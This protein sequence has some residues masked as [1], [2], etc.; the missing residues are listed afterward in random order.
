[1]VNGPRASFAYKRTDSLRLRSTEHTSNAHQQSFVL[2]LFCQSLHNTFTTT[3]DSIDHEIAHCTWSSPSW[4]LQLACQCC[5][6]SCR[7]YGDGALRASQCP[8]RASDW[9]TVSVPFRW[10][11]YTYKPTVLGPRIYVLHRHVHVLVRVSMYELYVRET[12]TSYIYSIGPT[13]ASSCPTI[14]GSRTPLA[15]PMDPTAESV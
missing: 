14:C 2:H 12:L 8:R 7:A 3:I 10:W 4:A 5:G 1:M 15:A 6:C 11:K 9:D 13:P